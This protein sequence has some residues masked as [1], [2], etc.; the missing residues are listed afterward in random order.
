MGRGECVYAVGFLFVTAMLWVYELKG[1]GRPRNVPQE[2]LEGIW[3]EPPF[4]YLF[5]RKQ[6]L[7][8]VLEWLGPN[9]EWRLTSRYSLPYERWQDISIPQINLGSFVIRLSTGPAE[10]PDIPGG[11]AIRLDPGIVFGSGLHPTT[12]GCLL[13]ISGIFG[14]NEIHT[15]VDL[16]T[17]TGILAVACA[18]AGAKSVLAIDRNPLALKISSKNAQTN[19]V[20]DKITFIEA[21]RLGV[22]DIRPDLLIMNLEWLILEGVLTAGEW[23]NA[24]RV[25][26][27]GFLEGKLESVKR[28]V[29]PHFLVE[30]LIVREGWPTV[31]LARAEADPQ[32]P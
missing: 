31:T 16:G 6:S 19:G 23:R 13:A 24:G 12:Q 7:E 14:S 11:I 20:S 30:T 32:R 10:K 27:A 9:P 17:G 2:G 18:L 25:V 4:Y 21:D 28:F 3:P 5:Y 15:A 1:S 22:I 29:R 8:S 26:L